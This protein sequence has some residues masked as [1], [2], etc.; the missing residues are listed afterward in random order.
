M[1]RCNRSMK[2]VSGKKL[3]RLRIKGYTFKRIAQKYNISVQKATY[4]VY[5]EFKKMF[6]HCF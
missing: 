1:G 6:P 5:K 4:L 2:N 3:F